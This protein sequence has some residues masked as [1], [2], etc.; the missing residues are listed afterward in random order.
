MKA[1]LDLEGSDA[2]RVLDDAAEMLKERGVPSTTRVL[3]GDPVDQVG[4]AIRD[5]PA[6]L[7]VVAT[8]A[9]AGIGGWMEGSFAQR[10]TS[11]LQLPTLLVR[12][13]A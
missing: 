7:L 5:R 6:D 10:I 13:P 12:A 9:R 2:Q 1:V 3:R 11:Q 4:R 8:H